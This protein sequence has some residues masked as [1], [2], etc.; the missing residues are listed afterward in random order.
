M[1][2]MQSISILTISRECEKQLDQ[3]KIAEDATGYFP[4]GTWDDVRYLGKLSLEHDIKIATNRELVGA[5]L[6]EKLTQRIRRIKN[7]YRLLSLLL[8]ITPEPIIAMYCFFDGERFRRALYLVHDYVAE[9]FGVVSLYRVNESSSS[10]VVAHGLGHSR[11][12][13]HHLEPIDLMYPELLKTP[14]LQVEGFCKVC[15]CKLTHSGEKTSEN[16][17]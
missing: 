17:S 15:L 6:F 4:T 2:I 7:S 13:R 8:G 14:T 3:V 5:F 1:S 10:K 12:L 9:T 16:D 11:G